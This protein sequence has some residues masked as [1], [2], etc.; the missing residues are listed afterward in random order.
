[1]FRYFLK[2]LDNQSL[3]PHGICLFWRPELLWTHVVSDALIFAAYM[4]IPAALAVIIRKRRDIPFGWMI[5]CFAVFIT[6]CGFTH[7]MGI[8]TLWHPDYGIE[9]LI[10]LITAISSVAT[11]LALWS[12]IPVA[13]AIPSP[14]RLRQIN[15]ELERRIEERDQAIAALQKEKEE[16]QKAEG[17]L[18]QMQKMDALGQLTGGIAHDF[19][20]LLQAIQGSLDLI[21]R[22]AGDPLKVQE[23]SEGGLNA[24]RRGVHLTSKLLA[25]SRTKQLKMEPL[26][27][28]DMAA[29]MNELLAR[30]IG[31]AVDLRF[32][33]SDDE[34]AV[35]TDR[36]Q[37]ELALLNLVINARDAM[38][39]SGQ[40]V[41]RT[42]R[43]EASGQDADLQPG[44]Y[45]RLSVIDN[46][47]GMP[48]EVE[49]KAFDP[50]FTTKPVGQGTGLGLSQVY[51]FARQTGGTARIEQAPGHGA[52]VSVYI[53]VAA[54]IPAAKPERRRIARTVDLPLARILVVDDDEW[55]RKAA[56]DTLETM[57]MDVLQ[58][59][60]GAS[61]LSLAAS[62][63]PDLVLMDLV[64][65]GLSGAETARRR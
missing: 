33:L 13:V 56:V 49:Q 48:A 42:D 18:I 21:S 36:N 53:P 2:L 59:A 16:R 22:R 26:Y 1:M 54:A 14:A 40:I 38:D 27:L 15:Q 61:A 43:Y 57:G 37:A 19:N 55:V 5:W 20:N 30:T 17:A 7:F 39:A 50:F 29:D 25:F 11:A 6:A 63:N 51:G 35:M 58:A 44:P 32:E 31:G 34:A 24:A 12:L 41:I 52:V 23:L 60:D 9:A 10:K 3:S 4:T 28:A 65:P 8:W 46:G 47:P 45:M 64:M 62:R